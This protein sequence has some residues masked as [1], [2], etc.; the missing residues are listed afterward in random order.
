M[1][2][3]DIQAVPGREVSE[4][5]FL[6]NLR[7]ATGEKHKMLESQ[8][9]LAALMSPEVTMDHYTTHLSLMQTIH[10]VF[11]QQLLPQ[12]SI[13]FPDKESILM[14]GLISDDLRFLGGSHAGFLPA[15]Y[16]LPVKTPSLAYALGFL[17][18]L[19]GSKL[20]G[21]VIFKHLQKTLGISGEEGGK[22]L[23]DNGANTGSNWKRF[24]G[25]FA[26]YVTA[27]QLEEEAIAGA[28]DAFTSIYTYY[29]SNT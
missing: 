1:K 10:Q 29:Q 27:R 9:L 4:A 13:L 11:E 2:D 14:S 17:Y 22:Y 19:E 5:V 26:E 16:A 20:G 8:G 23:T 15:A 3:L 28:N 24:L 6:N 18:V 12:L 25:V 21:K 7:M